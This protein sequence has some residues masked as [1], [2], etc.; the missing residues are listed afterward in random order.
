M[1]N[2]SKWILCARAITETDWRILGYIEPQS[3]SD[4]LHSRISKQYSGHE[5]YG[6]WVV[7]DNVV[8][9]S[10]FAPSKEVIPV[11]RIFKSNDFI[12]G[13][14]DITEGMEFVKKDDQYEVS[15][16]VLAAR[17]GF[18]MAVKKKEQPFVIHWKK[19]IA[20]YKPVL[21]G[22]TSFV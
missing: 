21:K 8:I 14:A 4:K 3:D 11:S 6:I 22:M 19:L 16:R 1:T 2:K 9:R 17:E 10:T 12:R 7:V 20:Q 13:Y 5:V 15:L 18:I